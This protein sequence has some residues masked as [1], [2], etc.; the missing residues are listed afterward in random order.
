[1]GRHIAI[2]DDDP[3]NLKIAGKM[4]AK[5]DMKVSCIPSGKALLSFVKN[6]FIFLVMKRLLSI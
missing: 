6:L 4:L 5:H 1:M 3:I 2:V